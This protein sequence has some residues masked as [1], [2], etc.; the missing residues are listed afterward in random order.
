VLYG[1]Y[2]SNLKNLAISR[3]SIPSF[4]SAAIKALL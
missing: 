4:S 1:F 3:A 2:R